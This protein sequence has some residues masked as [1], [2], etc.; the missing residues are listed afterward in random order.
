MRLLLLLRPALCLVIVSACSLHGSGSSFPAFPEVV[1]QY[2]STYEFNPQLGKGIVLRF[3]KKKDG[4]HVAE[5]NV[6]GRDVRVQHF[7]SG[8]WGK[9]L[10]LDHYSK[11]DANSRTSVE[12]EVASFLGSD[13]E[14][15]SYEYEHNI[16][17]G[18]S[19]WDWDVIQDYED[20]DKLSD[21]QLEGLAN[22]YTAY[23]VGFVFGPWGA[24]SN[25]GDPDRAAV[26]A[27][28]P[29][30][31]SRRDKFILYETRAVETRN[32]LYRQNPAYRTRVGSMQVKL[33]NDYVFAW[34]NLQVAGYEKEA[35]KFL[36][37]GIYPDSLL[38]V[39]RAY[40]KDAGKNAIVVTGGDND[41]YPVWYVQQVE[42]YRPDVSVVSGPL[43]AI[44]RYLVYLNTQHKGTFFHSPPESYLLPAFDFA[45]YGGS[46]DPCP[47][48]LL[49]KDFLVQMNVPPAAPAMGAEESLYRSYSCRNIQAALPADNLYAP[50]KKGSIRFT[51]GNILTM[52]DFM[53]L[54]ILDANLAT[55]QLYFTQPFI[56]HLFKDKLMPSGVLYTMKPDN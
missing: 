47:D 39:A 18:Y 36:K 52:W 27:N 37:R 17:Y 10:S 31:T 2:F 56:S 35:A 46:K 15:S 51:L 30:S 32:K 41:T 8:L 43:L 33:A 40:L 54:D 25:A 19:G 28:M 20:E 38:Q 3:Q 49:L 23:A 4:W 45:V 24:L 21:L 13:V 55:R 16:Y 6:E 34:Y 50:G 29:I 7:W 1:R 22:A 9:Y 44:R 11:R 48:P 14:A 26:P 53:L 42:K 5:A 12:E